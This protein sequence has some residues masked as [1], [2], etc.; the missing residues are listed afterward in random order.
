MVQQVCS[1]RGFEEEHSLENL[2][3]VMFCLIQKRSV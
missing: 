1:V 2:H 3:S